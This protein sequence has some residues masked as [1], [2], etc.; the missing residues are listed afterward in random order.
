MLFLLS[1]H[2]FLKKSFHFYFYFY[3]IFLFVFCTCQTFHNNNQLAD[4]G[5]AVSTLATFILC[6][7]LLYFLG[8]RFLVCNC[9]HPHPPFLL[10]F[11]LPTI[12]SPL[13]EAPVMSNGGVSEKATSGGRNY[14]RIIG[15][16][17]K[18]S[19]LKTDGRIRRQ[20]GRWRLFDRGYDSKISLGKMES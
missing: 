15:S 20:D 17:H 1:F 4:S 16:G 5:L 3:F 7:F 18:H 10:P 12:A 13:V 6:I 8:A 14:S 2:S 9:F 11:R 19:G